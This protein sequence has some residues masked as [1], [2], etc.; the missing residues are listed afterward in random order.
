MNYQ[1]PPEDRD[2][3]RASTFTSTNWPPACA[4]PSRYAPT[5][6]RPHV[7]L[8]ELGDMAADGAASVTVTTTVSDS[9]GASLDATA[10]VLSQT[11]DPTGVDRTAVAHSTVVK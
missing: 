9:A 6:E 3:L 1:R 8:C 4:R 7:V 5:E 11:A 10:V 2:G